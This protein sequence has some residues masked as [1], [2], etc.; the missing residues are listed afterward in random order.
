MLPRLLFQVMGVINIM[1]HFLWILW[2]FNSGI[3]ILNLISRFHSCI[4]LVF[5]HLLFN[6]FKSDL[7]MLAS[8]ILLE[9]FQV[10][11]IC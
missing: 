3:I 2:G 6:T 5:N 4:Y 7:N 10:N 11:L 9:F 1:S 8:L